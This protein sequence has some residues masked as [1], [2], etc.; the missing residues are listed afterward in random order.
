M[1]DG[2]YGFELTPPKNRFIGTIVY[3]YITSRDQSGPVLHNSGENLLEQAGG[4]D[5]YYNHYYY[6][7]WQHWGMAICNPHTLSPLYNERSNLTMPYQRLRSHHFGVEGG[8]FSNWQYRAM[9]SWSKHW[10]SIKIPLPN[11]LTQLSLM[12][13]VTYHLARHNGWQF[14]GALALDRSGLIGNNYGGMLTIRRI[15]RLVER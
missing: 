9:A 1:K 14:T 3:E 6:Q 4:M 2:L 5:D 11:P 7:A 15:G 12:G 8:G 10:G 13:E